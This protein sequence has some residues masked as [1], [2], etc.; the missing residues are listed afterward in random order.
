MYPLENKILAHF[1]SRSRRPLTRREIAEQI[2]LRG[3]ERKLLTKSLQQL[4][5]SGLLEERK[6]KYRL[7]PPQRT[8]EGIFS[9][10]DKGF[11]FLQQDDGQR[12]DLFIPARFVGSAMDGDRL[13]VACR[14]STRDRRPYAEVIKVLQRAHRRLI[15][16]Y[17]PRGNGGEVW[18]LEQKLGGPI[19]VGKQAKINPGDVVEVEIEHFAAG[20]RDACGQ[21][22]EVLGSPEDPQVDIETVIRNYA[23]PQNFSPAAL[24]QAATVAES[25]DGDEIARRVDL[26]RLPLVTID[27]ETAKDFDDA[28]ALQKKSDGSYRLWVCIADVSHYV[29]QATALDQ[30]ALERATSVYFPGFCLPMLPEA[31]S[32]GICSL[33][34]DEE[35]LVMA[36]ELQFDQTGVPLAAKFYPAV[37]CS[38]ARL[39][40]TQVAACLTDPQ[41][42]ALEN[43][44]VEQLA[45]MDELARLLGRQRQQ[46]GSL[47]M[48]LPELE[49][50][51]DERGCPVDLVKT[52]R[53]PA[54]RLIEEFMLAA[55][56][57]VAGFL[58]KQGWP[59][60]YRIHEKPDLEKLQELQQLAAECG[61]GLVLGK[62][63]QQGLQQLLIDIA[64]KPEARLVNQQLLRSLKQACYSPNNSGH[65]GLAADCYCHFTS[66]I[67][68]YPD[69]IVHRILKL[70]LTGSPKSASVSAAEL[71]V[72]GRDCSAKERR[73]MQAERNLIDLRRCQVMLGRVGEE[74]FGTISSVAEFGFFVELDDLYVEGLV[75]L[76]TLKNDYY[77]FDPTLLAL[78]GERHRRQFK[79]GMRVRVKLAKVELWRRRIDFTLVEEG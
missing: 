29:E 24:E 27:G 2:N 3:G 19:R 48:D 26:R 72:L 41:Q 28:V 34:P 6:G 64:E 78:L 65:F 4:V 36:A 62:N 7:V 12:E 39:T 25:I 16:F 38:Q 71:L 77:H 20:D 10:A 5:R 22:I 44:L 47:D 73:A 66:P 52:E 61:V 1:S 17:R 75:H 18:P 45:A 9:V 58:H 43:S 40:Y 42:S 15:G 53:T 56:E 21:I 23:L 49:V 35:R 46:R 50:L 30:D 33:K 13:L 14:V 59:F 31:L 60:L 8:V 74:F 70:A 76:R 32:N 51:L 69:L 37:I 57:S 67:R 68:R 63:P 11:G 55:N 79:I 54:H